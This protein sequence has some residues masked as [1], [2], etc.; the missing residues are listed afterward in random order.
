M[1][2]GDFIYEYFVRPALDPAVAGYNL[3]NTLVYSAILIV[4]SF[5]VIYPYMNSKGVRFTTKFALAILPY[6]LFGS[7][8]R[9]LEDMGIFARSV[10]PLEFGYYTYTPGIYIAVALI[11]LIALKISRFLSRKYKMDVY[12]T[13][14]GIGLLFAVP[15][16]LFEFSQFQAW[17][18]FIYIIGLVLVA[19]Y[20]TVAIVKKLLKNKLLD[21]NLNKLALAGQ[22]LDGFATYV[23]IGVYNCGEQHVLS[24]GVINIFGPLSFPIVKIVLIVLIL[25]YIDREVEKDNFRNFLKLFIIIL[26][27]A[28]GTRDLFT[29][30][31]GTCL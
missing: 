19:T 29:V 22:A 13:F 21:D 27:F 12:K 9:V 31:V 4:I 28:T 25:Y 11:T 17:E 18:G 5:L 1:A 23:A 26:G 30:G 2:S 24:G 14:A 6:I 16:V 3:V 15:V 7:S 8:F 20:L 10:N